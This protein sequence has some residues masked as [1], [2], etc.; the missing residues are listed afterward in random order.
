[1]QNKMV[2]KFFHNSKIVHFL[3]VKSEIY[4]SMPFL[5]KIDGFSNL[6]I[7]NFSEL[8]SLQYKIIMRRL[9]FKFSENFEKFRKFH[10]DK[11]SL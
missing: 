10:F 6:F 9:M 7:M 4:H 8:G 5:I 3:G 2:V 1:M 11:M